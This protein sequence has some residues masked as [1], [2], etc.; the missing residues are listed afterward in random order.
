MTEMLLRVGTTSSGQD[1]QLESTRPM[2]QQDTR[3]PKKHPTHPLVFTKPQTKQPAQS[4]PLPSHTLGFRG[5]IAC[6]PSPSTLP[7]F[8]NVSPHTHTLTHPHT[9]TPL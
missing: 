8:T 9:F 3:R 2:Q 6:R 5:V 1:S 7:F 4:P